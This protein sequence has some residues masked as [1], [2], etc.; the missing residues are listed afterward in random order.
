M[1][2][3]VFPGGHICMVVMSVLCCFK[4]RSDAHASTNGLIDI[5]RP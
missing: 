5:V 3:P 2:P 1:W 4:K